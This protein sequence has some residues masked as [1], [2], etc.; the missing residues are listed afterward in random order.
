MTEHGAQSTPTTQKE[1][2][3]VTLTKKSKMQKFI[4]KSLKIQN[5]KYVEIKEHTPK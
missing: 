4:Y 2:R 1:L 3:D 5:L